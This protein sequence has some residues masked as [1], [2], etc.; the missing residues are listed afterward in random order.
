MCYYYY[1]YYPLYFVFSFL[2]TFFYIHLWLN[3]IRLR[4]LYF[5]AFIVCFSSVSS[6]YCIQFVLSL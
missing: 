4:Y 2:C 1:Y 6:V 3:N 5:V